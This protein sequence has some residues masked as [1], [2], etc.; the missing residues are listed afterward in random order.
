MLRTVSILVGGAAVAAVVAVVA[1]GAVAN[2]VGAARTVTAGAAAVT[3]VDG[4][5]SDDVAMVNAVGSRL[6]T[7]PGTE[8]SVIRA[9]GVDIWNA[10]APDATTVDTEAGVLKHDLLLVTCR[11]N[12]EQGDYKGLAGTTPPEIGEIQMV[13]DTATGNVLEITRIPKGQVSPFAPA[14]AVASLGT[15]VQLTLS[16]ASFAG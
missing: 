12:V 13:I 4:L 8:V 15:P 10:V 5:S 3:S 14:G 2:H 16:A 6:A 9:S 1:V 7:K 11:Q